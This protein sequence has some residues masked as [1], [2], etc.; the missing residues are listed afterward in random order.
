[1]DQLFKARNEA[2]RFLQLIRYNLRKVHEKFFEYFRSILSQ[3]DFIMS[4]TEGAIKKTAYNRKL[5]TQL[6]QRR[7]LEYISSTKVKN[8]YTKYKEYFKKSFIRCKGL[9]S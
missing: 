4:L 8:K 9:I 7:I 1:M 6:V 2:G 5:S 3:F